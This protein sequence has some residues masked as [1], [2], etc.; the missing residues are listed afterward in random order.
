LALIYKKEKADAVLHFPQGDAKVLKK[1]LRKGGTWAM[2]ATGSRYEMKGKIKE[3][4]QAF[5]LEALVLW[6]RRVLLTWSNL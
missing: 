5:S 6:E 1:L 2:K 3:C 4:R